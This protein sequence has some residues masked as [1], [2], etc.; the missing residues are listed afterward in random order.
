DPGPATDR[1]DREGARQGLRGPG[2]EVMGAFRRV[3]AEKAG[4]Q[5][6]G[7]LVPP[8]KRTFVILRPRSLPW[9]LVLLRDAEAGAFRDLAHD[10]ASA[11]AQALYRGLRE[12]VAGAAPLLVEIVARAG[13]CWVRAVVGPL[14][15]LACPRRPGQPY[16]PLLCAEADAAAHAASLTAVLRPAE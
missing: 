15:L 14:A 11:A 10:E 3:E 6:L 2:S 8:S 5:A 12:G 9:D 16:Q 13:G 1:S 4:A 7:I